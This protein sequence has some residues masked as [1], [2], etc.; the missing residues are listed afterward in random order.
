[1]VQRSGCAV[2]IKTRISSTPH[3]VSSRNTLAMEAL[4]D[5]ILLSASR[6]G[7]IP[8]VVV[9]EDAQPTIIDLRPLLT[10]QNDTSL[11][12]KYELVANS[13]DELFDSLKIDSDRETLTLTH[14][15]DAFGETQITVGAGYK[16]ETPVEQQFRVTVLPVN[17]RPTTIGLSDITVDPLTLASQVDLHAAFDDLEDADADLIFEITQN[18]N[19]SLFRNLEINATGELL[20]EY[21][22][23]AMGSSQLTIRATDTEGLSV[24]MTTSGADFPIYDYILGD[25]DSQR[26]DDISLEDM[27][28]VSSWSMF[29]FVDGSYDYS[30]LDEDHFRSVL[31]TFPSDQPIVFNIEN[32][33]YDNS[34]E[35]RDRMARVLQITHEERP[36]LARVGF[37]RLIPQRNWFAPV[38]WAQVREHL[39]IGVTSYYTNHAFEMQQNYEAWMAFNE[40]YRTAPISQE[41]GGERVV[42]SRDAA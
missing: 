17:D 22:P 37:Y 5:R 36:D 18:S 12:P 21:P 2:R 3:G 42:G 40:L 39:A 30:R 4:E 26:S 6:N 11:R 15:A 16:G 29:P 10:D 28:L 38:D 13:D 14:A 27:F 7:G 31:H 34:P 24:E 8:D 35:G 41:F 25:S 9:G 33:Y 1:M 32:E 20:L 23:G 19:P